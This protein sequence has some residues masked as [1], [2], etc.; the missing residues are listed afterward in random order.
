MLRRLEIL[1]LRVRSLFRSTD[2]D[3]ELDRELRFHVDH[4]IAELVDAGLPPDDARR[5][6]LR[7][8]GSVASIV[9]QCRETRRV[10]FVGNITQDV[11]YAVR[12]FMAQPM[13]F[14]AATTSIALGVGANLAIFGVANSLLLSTPSAAQPER[15][16]H[17]RTGNGSHA[18][19]RAWRQLNDSGVLAG[20]AGHQIE[21]TV[22]WRGPEFSVPIAPLIVTPNFFDV[23][24]VPMATGRGFTASEAER[25]AHVA[26]VSYRFWQ[27]RLD[28]VPS[29]LGTSLTLNGEAFTVIG[30]T[31]AGLRSFPGF[32]LVPDVWL[33]VSRSLAPN[34][35]DPRAAHVQLIGR[36]KDGQDRGT[37]VA[38]LATV[39]SRVGQDLGRPDVGRIASVSAVNG[40]EQMREFKEVAAFFAVLL[41]VTFLVLAIACANVAGLL[42]ARGSARRREIAVRLALGATR[43]RLV[44]QLL[45][46]GFVLS[47]AGTAAALG[48]LGLLGLLLPLVSLPFPI[49]VELHLSFDTR[50]AVFA[51]ALVVASSILCGLAPAWQATRPAL[52]PALKQVAVPYVHRRFTL[53]NVLVAGQIAVSALLLVTTALFL[54][55]LALA[56]TLSPGFD[57]DRAI[58]AQITFVEGRQGP[59]EAPAVQR[60]VQ[61]LGSLP[62]VEVAAFSTGVPLTMY[63]GRT[64]T[65]VKIEGREKPVRVDYQDNDVSPGYFRALGIQVLLGREFSAADRVGTPLVIVINQEFVRRYFD[66][67]DPVGLHVF[68]PT[69]PEPTPAQV[70]GVVADSKYSTIGEGRIPALY[71]AYLQGAASRRFVHAIVR[72]TGEPSS[73]VASVRDATLQM[74]SSTAVTVQPMTSVLAFAF[75]PSRVGAAL[76]GLLGALGAA[77]AMVGLYGV[78]AFAV[79]RRTSEIGIRIALGA[80]NQNVMR[81]VL[82]ESVVL[83]A[84]GL[85]LG[86]AAAFFITP[87]L[88]A[89]LVA[90]LPSRDPVSFSASSILLLLTS[91]V[92]SWTPARRATRIAPASAL[93]AE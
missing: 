82:S 34:L 46:E 7:N 18:P 57:A 45:S 55:N 76:V 49:P 89:F 22:N 39:G 51:T 38:A 44:Q 48:L 83:V 4:H 86:L 25:D 85:I 84:A 15:L 23:V 28:A 6:A 77:L 31:A 75:L 16:V 70:I 10:N 13:L 60:I 61:R 20:I 47:V 42:L 81:L 87:P 73:V 26:V 5:E 79:S 8:F 59:R 1:R 56:H 88:A 37:A 11:R 54:R 33:P 24:G 14:A 30:V 50:L 66:G 41:V 64:G 71:T 62:G 32:G 29:I 58:I 93:R 74:D 68:L 21:W 35:D 19:Y 53:R 91:V 43:S 65:D 52:M 72:T 3:R 80:S 67:H 9:D 36:L 69:D 63:T 90:E 12:T 78:V 40:L 27:R 2:V 17:I 92:A